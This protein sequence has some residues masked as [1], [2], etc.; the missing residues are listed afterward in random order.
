MN[1]SYWSWPDQQ[2]EGESFHLCTY[3]LVTCGS[4][5]ESAHLWY[6][7]IPTIPRSLEWAQNP[8]GGWGD[9]GTYQ[10]GRKILAQGSALSNPLG[11]L[12]PHLPS[13]GAS[14]SSSPPKVGFQALVSSL[15]SM[16]KA[17]WC[18]LA[19]NHG[20]APGKRLSQAE[21]LSLPRLKLPQGVPTIYSFLTQNRNQPSSLVP[22]R[23]SHAAREPQFLHGG[24]KSALL[25]LWELGEED[26]E[27]QEYSN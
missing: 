19:G 10:T 15:Q 27:R 4:R 9:T 16:D 22:S 26:V 18:G 20:T 3:I 5:E 14:I 24:R 17:S 6:S 25:T 12:P 2:E 21:P 8:W 13:E 23:A 1:A 7:L 11:S